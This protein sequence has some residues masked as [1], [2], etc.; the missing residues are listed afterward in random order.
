MPSSNSCFGPCFFALPSYASA[1]T[2]NVA[3]TGNDTTGNGS[4]ENPW[5]TLQHA[6]DTVVDGDTVHVGAGI[7]TED[8][9]THSWYSLK[10]VS[11]IADGEVVVHA[12]AAGIRVLSTG[13]IKA[14]SFD[15]FTFDADNDID[16]AKSYAVTFSSSTANKTFSNCIFRDATSALISGTSLSNIDI[17]SSTF[18]MNSGSV[19]GIKGSYADSVFSDNT[20]NATAG[21]A[22]VRISSDGNSATFD[23]NTF[24]V[25]T[26]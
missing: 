8:S 21:L 12:V 2:Y 19:S 13:G 23:G 7:Y 17:D 5:L 18:N 9:M 14:A 3:K 10:E 22:T 16:G 20:F 6:E 4:V 15:G 1:A 11:W 25:M 24:R 26:S